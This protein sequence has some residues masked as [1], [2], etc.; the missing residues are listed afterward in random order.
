MINADASPKVNVESRQQPVA[1]KCTE[2]A[3]DE[4]ANKPKTATLHHSAGQP[5]RDYSHNYDD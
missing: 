4:I 5:A 1:Y 3:Y 2:Q